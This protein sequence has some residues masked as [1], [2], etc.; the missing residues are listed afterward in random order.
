MVDIGI[1]S[2]VLEK[3]LHPA[4]CSEILSVFCSTQQKKVFFLSLEQIEIDDEHLIVF[5]I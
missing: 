3:V 4:G 2:K 1:K 5:N